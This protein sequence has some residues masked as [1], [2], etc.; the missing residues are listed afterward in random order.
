L[1]V[2]DFLFDSSA[3]L[4]NHAHGK[5]EWRQKG[6]RRRETAAR[7]GAPA[8]HRYLFQDFTKAMPGE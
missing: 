4:F 7:W 8:S 5:N 2:F 1:A 6:A 3:T